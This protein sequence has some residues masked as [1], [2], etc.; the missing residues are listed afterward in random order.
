MNAVPFAVGVNGFAGATLQ[1]LGGAVW[2]AAHVSVTL[3][4]YPKSDVSI[5][6]KGRFAEVGNMVCTNGV[7]VTV[8]SGMVMFSV[9]DLGAGAPLVSP[10]IETA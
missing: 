7:A 5:P 8:K 10:I 6:V 9:T 3:L 2:P 4:A 1:V